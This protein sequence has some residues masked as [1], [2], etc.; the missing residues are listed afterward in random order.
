MA[1]HLLN[2]EKIRF[3]EI[4]L[5]LVNATQPGGYQE[6]VNGLVYVTRQTTVPQIFICGRFI[7]GYVELN[8]MHEAKNLWKAVN[9]CVEQYDRPVV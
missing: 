3:K 5:D 7:G 8:G 4:D 1:K 9:K 6:Y 2:E